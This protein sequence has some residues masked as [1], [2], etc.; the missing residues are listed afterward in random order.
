MKGC[1]RRK[2]TTTDKQGS[3]VKDTQG[4]EETTRELHNCAL[5]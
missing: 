1:R 2:T 4:R 5:P 3:E